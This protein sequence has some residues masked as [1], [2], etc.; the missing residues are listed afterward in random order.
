M[1]VSHAFGVSGFL[2]CIVSVLL[3]FV[4]TGAFF[5]A[6]VHRLLCAG[7]F[8][9]V[10][11]CRSQLVE[12]CF[13]FYGFSVALFEVNFRRFSILF[14]AMLLLFLSMTCLGSS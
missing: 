10:S 3:H 6:S 2:V 11:S 8:L 9:F 12:A 4:C 13:G 7:S 14:F 1:G 5:L